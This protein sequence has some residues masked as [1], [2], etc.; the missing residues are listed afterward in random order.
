MVRT[1]RW[2]YCSVGRSG[3]AYFGAY[4][5]LLQPA[6]ALV[7]ISA[8]RLSVMGPTMNATSPTQAVD[9]VICS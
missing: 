1:I 3:R 4:A 5:D 9:A 7:V 2:E 6:S 8:E